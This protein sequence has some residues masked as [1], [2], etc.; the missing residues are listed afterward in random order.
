VEEGASLVAA[1]AAIE[2][3]VDARGAARVELAATRVAGAVRIE[4]A[5]G[6]VVLFGVTVGNGTRIED[7]R[8]P[9]APLVAGG[10]LGG[11]IRCEGNRTAPE[12]GGTPPAVTGEAT[13]QCEG[14]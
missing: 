4:G 9:A 5:T 12:R 11:G 13:G 2:G 3:D 8:T 10:A 6:R 14:W 1:N 7:S